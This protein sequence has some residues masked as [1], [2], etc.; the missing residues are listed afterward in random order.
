MRFGRLALRILVA[1]AI[2]TIAFVVGLFLPVVIHDS[3]Y[4]DSG[5]GGGFITIG[6]GLPLGLLCALSVG[7]LSFK[8]IRFK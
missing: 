4:G 5:I 3:I 6:I 7:I 2:S 1:V 8:K